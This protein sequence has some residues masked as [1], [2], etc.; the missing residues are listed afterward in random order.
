MVTAEAVPSLRVNPMPPRTTQKSHRPRASHGMMVGTESQRLGLPSFATDACFAR[1][2]EDQGSGNLTVRW[3][4]QQCIFHG[5]ELDKLERILST[6]LWLCSTRWILDVAGAD[7][8]FPDSR[9]GKCR[10]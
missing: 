2:V 9:P 7:T 1:E 3:K 8:I 4:C 5:G 10:R 6:H